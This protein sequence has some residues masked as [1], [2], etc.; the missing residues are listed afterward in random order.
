MSIAN[1]EQ[2]EHWNSEEADHWITHRG[3][4]DQLLEPFADMLLEAVALE[5][6]DRVLDVGCGCGAT[7]LAVARVT[8][9][10]PVVGVDL[11]APMLTQARADADRA[12]LRNA[13]FEQADAQV[14]PFDA[15]AFDTVISRFGMM[16]FADPT[17]AFTNLRRATRPGGRVVF[18]CWQ[19]LTANE[20][21]LVPGA[22]LAH[23]VALPDLG[24]PGAPGAPGMFALADPERTR[25]VLTQAGWRD[26][27][28]TGRHARIH[29]G[30]CGTLDDALE[31]LR[32][33]SIGRTVLRDVD[34]DTAADALAAVREALAPYLT[35]DGVRLDAAVWLVTAR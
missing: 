33:G 19:G 35:D 9:P 30:G 1:H 16:F 11:S 31:F 26:I 25:A 10:A 27:S 2:A 15:A 5:A 24:A 23:H 4:Y 29:I 28:I 8:A 18:A 22:A 12:G 6:G 14:H 17:A 13:R 34:A 21:L 3:R 32:T 20:W 7:T